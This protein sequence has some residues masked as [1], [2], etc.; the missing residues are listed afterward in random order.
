[1]ENDDGS[2]N[3]VM[4]H[5][6]FGENEQIFGYIKPQLKI[7]YCSSTL[8]TYINFKFQEK[9]DSEKYEGVK[10]DEVLKKVIFNT[11]KSS[12]TNNIDK[13]SVSIQEQEKFKPYGVKMYSYTRTCKF[14]DKCRTFEVYKADVTVPG[15]LDYHNKMQSFIKW[16][17]DGASF[18]DVDD[19]KWD[20][21]VLYEKE[22][23][24]GE[25]S[26]HFVGYSTC[27]RFYAYPDKT[28]PRI[29]QVLILP[30]YQRHGHC[31]EL[32]KAIYHEYVSRKNVLDMTAEDP[33]EDFQR[34]RDFVDASNCKTLPQFN[35]PLIHTSSIKSQCQAAVKKF[36][37]NKRQARR[38][39][40]ILKLYNTNESNDKELADYYISVRN[41][42]AEPI[43]SLNSRKNRLAK[44]GH[45]KPQDPEEI[46]QLIDRETKEKIEEYRKVV[47]RL[48]MSHS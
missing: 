25:T 44:M 8:A 10:C 26:F 34:V 35:S 38:V 21:F 36:K 48:R 16:F 28:R 7:L 1:M 37:I 2:F 32:I 4:S 27:Y 40:D 9:L 11:L 13:F 15:F 29:S 39:A 45:M 46:E 20:F 18:I 31:A 30:P 43:K 24:C 14:S 12:Y 47:A 23:E 41:K 33:S 6:I 17:V 19:D 22:V 42:I 3:P 5:Q